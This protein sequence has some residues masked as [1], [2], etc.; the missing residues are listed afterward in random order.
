MGRRE[1]RQKQK[2]HNR[3]PVTITLRQPKD[4]PAAARAV[5]DFER[6]LKYLRGGSD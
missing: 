4:L 2:M 3:K 5:L 6:G 1:K